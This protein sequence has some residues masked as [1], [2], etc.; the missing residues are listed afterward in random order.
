MEAY[1]G[2][3]AEDDEQ[4]FDWTQQTLKMLRQ[5][6]ERLSKTTEALD[7]FMSDNGDIAYLS[8]L[9]SPKLNAQWRH[10]LHSI[11]EIWGTLAALKSERMKLLRLEKFCQDSAGAV[12]GYVL[13][14]PYQPNPYTLFLFFSV[15]FSLF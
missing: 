11:K 13:F 2:N 1:E 15:R 14:L 10:A 3:H 7:K 12:C 9:C 5:L 6:L 4:A 8:S